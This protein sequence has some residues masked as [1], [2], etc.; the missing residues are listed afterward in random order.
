M[1]LP[2]PAA[3]RPRPTKPL[4]KANAYRAEVGTW[5]PS[6]SPARSVPASA[7]VEPCPSAPSRVGGEDD[8]DQLDVQNREE[9]AERAAC[10]SS[11]ASLAVWPAGRGKGGGGCTVHGRRGR[12]A[13][14]A[15]V[16]G[17]RRVTS[18]E[19]ETNRHACV[20]GGSVG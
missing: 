1:P 5:P 6:S 15:T 8:E 12:V 19:I 17:R 18:G 11:P 3:A 20:M 16:R 13:R 9:E 14:V 4:P 10:G 2:R 7:A